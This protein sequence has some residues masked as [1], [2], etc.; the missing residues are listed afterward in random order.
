MRLQCIDFFAFILGFVLSFANG[1]GT[2]IDRE[3]VVRRFNPSRNANSPTTPIQVGNGNFAFGADITGLQ[4]IL[5]WNTLSTWSWHNTSFP[6]T[7][8]QTKPEDFTGLDW[9]THGR[10]VPYSQPNPA[11]NDISQW[12]IRNPHRV[13]LGRIGL[14]YNG[15][16]IEENQLSQTQQHLDMWTGTLHSNFT[17]DGQIVSVQTN[18]DPH[19]DTVAVLIESRLLEDGEVTVFFDFPYMT[20]QNKFETFVGDW[21]STSNHTTTIQRRQ[22]SAEIRHDLDSTTYFAT[23]NWVEKG[24]MSRLSASSHQY[25]LAPAGS[26]TFTFTTTFSANPIYL[27]ASVS[28][29][30]TSSKQWWNEYWTHGAFIDLT[31]SC[32]PPPASTL[33]RL[34]VLSQYLLAVNSASDSPPQESGLTNNGWYGKFHLEMYL[35]HG[36]HWAVWNR[37]GL[38]HR[39]LN[40]LYKQFLPSSQLRAAEQGYKGA[41]WGKMSD[42]SGRSAPGE[43]NSLLIWQ[44][45]HPL[46]FAELEYQAALEAKPGVSNPHQVLEDWDQVLTATADFMTSYAFHNSSTGVFDLGP[47][48]YPV[49]ENTQPNNTINPTFELAYWRFGLEVA[50]KWK[51]RQRKPTPST[52]ATVLSQLAPLPVQNGTYVIYEGVQDPWNTPTLTEDHPGLVGIFGF[53]PP[54]TDSPFN[55]TTLNATLDKINSTWNFTASYGWDF[56]FLAMNAARMGNPQQA[57]K[58][59][60]DPNFAFDDIGMPIGGSRVPT[61][62]FPASAGLLWA[63]GMMAG[64]WASEPKSK[65]E[66]RWPNGW[67]VR[68]EDFGKG[69]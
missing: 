41:R 23:I 31:S 46:H 68:V 66:D 24:S 18:V 17:L 32:N 29:I 45:P 19:S 2:R 55:T 22:H 4:S 38:L 15:E 13:N 3:S 7:P 39:S 14:L 51:S 61:P 65:L 48:M 12:L 27:I 34:I 56:P 21:N 36:A 59:L 6:T 11:E 5:P 54:S 40:T 25:T 16:G 20:G 60:L 10:L 62:Y 30:N 67:E 35:W 9:W 37:W 8:G 64:G 26:K 69:L 33:Q 1:S 44:Q 28:T 49:S 52:W 43:I 53:L 50:S 58:W 57:V 42:P 63:V 47:P